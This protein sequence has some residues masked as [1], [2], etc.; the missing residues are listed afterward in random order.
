MAETAQHGTEVGHAEGHAGSPVFPP[1][2]SSTF[3][4]QLVWLVIVFG[5]LYLLMSRIAL[6]RVGEILEKRRKTIDDD[7][8]AAARLK[9]QTDDAIAAYEKALADARARAQAIASQTRDELSAQTEARRKSL[10]AELAGK[11]GAAEASIAA[12]RDKAMSNV[13]GIATDAAELI[14]ERL[15]SKAPKRGEV[16]AAVDGALKG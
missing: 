5:A 1:F 15:I 9:G 14:V 8:D 4:T 13:R 12:S 7:L 6:P 2:D 11:I 3:A 16:E 10:E